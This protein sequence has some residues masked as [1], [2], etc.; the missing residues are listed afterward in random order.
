MSSRN[1]EMHQ[2]ANYSLNRQRHHR[3]TGRARNG[4]TMICRCTLHADSCGR[5]AIVLPRRDCL[6]EHA[7]SRCTFPI[8]PKFELG[9][10][11]CSAN[12]VTWSL[13]SEFQALGGLEEARL[14]IHSFD[15]HAFHRR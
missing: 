8:Q 5:P 1:R 12:L 15:R 11:H 6:Y 13:E 14:A 2:S 9:V 7:L 3:F 10:G 4:K